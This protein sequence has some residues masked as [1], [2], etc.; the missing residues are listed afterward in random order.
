M[1]LLTTPESDS[2]E[3]T[4]AASIGC[5]HTLYGD[6]HPTAS[7]D[8][9]PP[10]TADKACD[11]ATQSAPTPHADGKQWT[12]LINLAS[13]YE[14][15][16][17]VGALPEFDQLQQLKQLTINGQSQ[18]FMQVTNPVTAETSMYKLADGKF[19]TL[20]SVPNS[21]YADEIK[22]L[23]SMAP[24]DGKVAFIN[25]SHGGGNEGLYKD[26]KQ[27]KAAN[28][29]T[30]YA[31]LPE[32][33]A[34]IQSG[35][36]AADKAQ[37]DLI[38]WDSCNMGTAAIISEIG[39]LTKN[40]VASETPEAV[41]G[42]PLV[43]IIQHALSQ[44]PLSGKELGRSLITNASKECRASIK[45][46][47]SS[48]CDVQTLA[49]Y[50]IEEEPK[51]TAALSKFGD[52]LKDALS[53]PENRKALHLIADEAP[54]SEEDGTLQLRDLQTFAKGVIQGINSGSVS[55]DHQH[56]LLDSA[57]AVIAAQA[58]LIDQQFIDKHATGQNGISVLLPNTTYDRIAFYDS[59]AEAVLVLNTDVEKLIASFELHQSPTPEAI[60][61][62]LFDAIGYL[63]QS[64]ENDSRVS[65]SDQ[66]QTNS[67]PTLAS[68][69]QQKGSI[70]DL[71]PLRQTLIRTASEPIVSEES[72][73]Q[74]SRLCTK[75]SQTLTQHRDEW[76]RQN[77]VAGN[78]RAAN[79][80]GSQ[81]L[82][83]PGGWERF[84]AKFTTY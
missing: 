12:Y 74:L 61:K 42:Q 26:N 79:L 78:T 23:V 57:K 28:N 76:F 38:S 81:R 32:I 30:N 73:R 39:G 7:V 64:L 19:Q 47:P 62:P 2:P 31:S 21:S 44:P 29:P 16:P 52:A 43:K 45:H 54:S 84:I 55:D 68:L 35:L 82:T 1:G 40:L 36:K 8:K 27:D 49:L 11:G 67:G 63:P 60:R 51:F 80:L 46:D 48:L 22:R 77:V 33:S 24:T 14:T 65:S 15:A 59:A 5:G 37:L 83:H 53:T 56:M 18:L 71:E 34:A 6:S 50:N 58:K 17:P 72:L 9:V 4:S 75:T 25:I 3:T 13:T 10:T 20:S 41:P 69:L 66:N 70:E